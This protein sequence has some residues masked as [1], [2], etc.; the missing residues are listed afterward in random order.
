M[1]VLWLETDNF[2]LLEPGR[3][4][5]GEGVNVIT[6]ANAQGKTTLLEAADLLTGMKSFRTFTTGSSLLST[7]RRPGSPAVWRPPAGS[8]SWSSGSIGA[9]QGSCAGTGRSSPPGR[10]GTV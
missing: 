4:E 3:V 1:R 10:C 7:G 8:R 9:G 5:L 6:G 2:R